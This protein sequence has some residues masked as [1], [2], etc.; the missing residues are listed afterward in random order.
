MTGVFASNRPR[1]TR[2]RETQIEYPSRNQAGRAIAAEFGLNP[3]YDN[4]VWFQVLRIA[5]FGRFGDVETGA[6]IQ[7]DGRILGE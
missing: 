2:D 5:P 6:A 1:P 3:P 7:P 4:F